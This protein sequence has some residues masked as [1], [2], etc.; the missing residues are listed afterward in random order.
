M[1]KLTSIDCEALPF[2][3]RVQFRDEGEYRVVYND[4]VATKQHVEYDLKIEWIEYIT[5]S[6]W[7]LKALR[8]S[9]RA[10]LRSIQGCSK[11]RVMQSTLIDNEA[12]KNL[13]ARVT[14]K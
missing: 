11:L 13:T 10:T 8:D 2:L 14:M 3:K 9:V 12:W 7:F 5:L 6:P 1:K 4:A